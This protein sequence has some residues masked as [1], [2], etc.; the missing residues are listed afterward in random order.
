MYT[1]NTLNLLTKQ[2]CMDELT[3]L[4]T[5]LM[6][7]CTHENYNMHCEKCSATND[8]RNYWRLYKYI[9]DTYGN[10]EEWLTWPE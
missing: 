1:Y 8:C 6:T 9:R 10:E 5:K 7:K 4:V 2:E 3:H